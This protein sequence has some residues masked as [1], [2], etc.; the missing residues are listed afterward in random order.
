MPRR[1]LSLAR[2]A[3]E[4]STAWPDRLTASAVLRKRLN[5]TRR[6]TPVTPTERALA[7]LHA[8]EH[9]GGGIRVYAGSPDA[10]PE[11]SGYIVPTLAE[12][13]ATDL[14]RRVTEWLVSVQRDDG[15]ILGTD[16][17]PYVFDTA[18]VLRGLL[19]SRSLPGVNE[20]IER[21]YYYMF[22]QIREDGRN[23]FVAQ[24]RGEIP[25]G[26]LVYALPPFREAATLLGDPRGMEASERATDFYLTDP[27]TLDE[28]ELTH[29]L[30]YCLE[31]LIDI[32]RPAIAEPVLTKLERQQHRSGAVRGRD[33]VSWVC[34]PGLI[35]L[36]LCWLKVGRRGPAERAIAWARAHQRRS[37]GFLGSYGRHASYFARE[38]IAW[39]AKYFLDAERAIDD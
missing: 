5:A 13:G 35:Q 34:T 1:I 9:P 24:Y 8:N 10:Y 15:A 26:I 38:E 3:L 23:G 29:F 12:Y 11:V 19:V 14:A 25:E 6:G 17:K 18:Q 16:A 20:A 33:G 2:S 4:T 31:G 30:A 37:G 32:G 39:A 22:D 21:A 27:R 28:R 7:W 36:A